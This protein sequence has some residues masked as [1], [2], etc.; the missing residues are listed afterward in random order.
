MRSSWHEKKENQ[1]SQ[2]VSLSHMYHVGQIYKLRPFLQQWLEKKSIERASLGR[3]YKKWNM[4]YSSSYHLTEYAPQKH[5]NVWTK[6]IRKEKG[7]EWRS[8]TEINHTTHHY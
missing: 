8:P 7:N 1:S 2:Y 4:C 5:D 6:N 3:N